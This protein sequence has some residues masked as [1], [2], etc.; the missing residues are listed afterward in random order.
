MTCLEAQSNIMAFI[1]KKLPEE[2][3]SDFVRHMRYCPNCA[4]ELEI[5][6]T[7]IVG[8]RQ[9]D[10]D[11]E[12]SQDF[13]KDLNDELDRLENR[14]KSAKRFKMSSV[15]AALILLVVAGGIFYSAVLAKVYNAEQRIKKERQGETYSYDYF[16]SYMEICA[17]NLIE[18]NKPKEVV[19]VEPTVYDRIHEF[20]ILHPEILNPPEEDEDGN[21]S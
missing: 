2:N 18:D 8:M 14:I 19:I 10:N 16:G 1:D 13:K 4:E 20:N 6:Y 12:M 3:V 15:V 9:L 11:R 5:Y 7:L 17:R 21:Q